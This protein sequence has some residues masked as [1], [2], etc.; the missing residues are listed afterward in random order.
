MWELLDKTIEEIK[1]KKL[2]KEIKLDAI[3]TVTDVEAFV[4]GHITTC[5][6]N[7]GSFRYLPYLERLLTLNSLI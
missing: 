2:P 4:G 7:R 6:A 5:R 3:T 1:Q